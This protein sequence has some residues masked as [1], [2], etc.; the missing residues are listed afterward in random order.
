MNIQILKPQLSKFFVCI[1]LMSIYGVR[2]N[3]FH[4]ALI[5]NLIFTVNVS[6]KQ[7][8]TILFH[9]YYKK[10][11]DCQ[12]SDNHANIEKFVV[13]SNQPVHVHRKLLVTKDHD[14][15]QLNIVSHSHFPQYIHINCVRDDQVKNDS[16]ESKAIIIPS[17]P[18]ES[19]SIFKPWSERNT[20]FFQLTL[21]QW[22]HYYLWYEFIRHRDPNN[23]SLMYLEDMLKKIQ[24]DIYV[25][26]L[27][28]SVLWRM[29]H[30]N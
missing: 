17:I 11:F 26:A 29:A 3:V 8:H 25:H 9:N 10:N 23:P 27:R 28:L 15:L 4:Q 18:P 14:T 21:D 22:Q 12:L 20:F 5:E 1:I 7:S 16:H 13:D 2:A 24:I 30:G 19:P 6:P